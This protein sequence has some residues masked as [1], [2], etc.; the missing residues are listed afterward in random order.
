MRFVF[1]LYQKYMFI[2]IFV[3]KYKKKASTRFV[4]MRSDNTYYL[5][6]KENMRYQLMRTHISRQNICIDQILESK[7]K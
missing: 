3:Y 1:Y 4:V 6:G 7:I 2:Y 5:V